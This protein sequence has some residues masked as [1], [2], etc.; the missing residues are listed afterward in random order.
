MPRELFSLSQTT[1]C[2]RCYGFTAEASEL[3][4]RTH[5]LL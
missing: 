1:R 2:L 5:D 4:R 3:A